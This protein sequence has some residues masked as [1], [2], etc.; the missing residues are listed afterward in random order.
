MSGLGTDLRFGRF[1]L[2][3][4]NRGEQADPIGE[5]PVPT[6][7]SCEGGASVDAL[8]PSANPPIPAPDFRATWRVWALSSRRYL[9]KPKEPLPNLGLEGSEEGPS[10]AD[11]EVVAPQEIVP[12]LTTA[13]EAAAEEE[14]A[15]AAAAE[16]EGVEGDVL[17]AHDGSAQLT[18]RSSPAAGAVLCAQLTNSGREG[19]A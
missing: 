3:R 19:G 10:P 16:A 6:F 12:A 14:A 5:P 1:T 15:E 4:L 7:G 13:S 2:G 8:M 9:R 11:L 17:T 18:K